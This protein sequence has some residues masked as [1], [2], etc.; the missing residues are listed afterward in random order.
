LLRVRACLRTPTQP[1][2]SPIIVHLSLSHL[3]HTQ[4]TPPSLPSTSTHVHVRSIG[5]RPA[6]SML[7]NFRQDDPPSKGCARSQLLNIFTSAD[8]FVFIIYHRSCPF[9]LRYA[10]TYCTVPLPVVPSSPPDSPSAV[11]VFKFPVW[12]NPWRVFFW[13][14]QSLSL[15][16]YLYRHVLLCYRGERVRERYPPPDTAAHTNCPQARLSY[17]QSELNFNRYEGRYIY[18][19]NRGMRKGEERDQ[20]IDN[21][22]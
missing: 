22:R 10:Y 20:G 15:S 21:N 1:P 14:A 4:P 8:R 3:Q 5:A 9:P 19:K 7:V 12:I 17:D 13:F 2:L 18:N 11:R 6:G 16:P